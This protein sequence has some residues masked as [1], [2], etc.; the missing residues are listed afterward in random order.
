MSCP[1]A[2][3]EA[4][5]LGWYRAVVVQRDGAEQMARQSLQQLG[6]TLWGKSRPATRLCPSLDIRSLVTTE[7]AVSL[8]HLPIFEQAGETSALTTSETPFVIP[9]ESLGA[10]SFRHGREEGAHRSPLSA[11]YAGDVPRATV[12]VQTGAAGNKGQPFWVTTDN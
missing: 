4:A 10:E 5:P 2:E 3:D 11:R 8:F 9:P 12:H 6:G 1:S 7:E